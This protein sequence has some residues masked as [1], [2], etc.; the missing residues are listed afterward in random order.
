MGRFFSQAQLLTVAAAAAGVAARGGQGNGHSSG[1]GAHGSADYVIV[2]AGPAGVVLAEQLSRDGTKSVVLIEAGPD[3][4]NNA[5]IDTP[6]MYPFITEQYWNYT[7]QPDDNLGGVAHALQQ[8]RTIGGGSGVNGMAYCRGSASVFDDWATLSGN[9]G[10]AWESIFQDFLEVSHYTENPN[11]DYD[12]VVN[13]SA[14]G[15]G[16]LEVSRVGTLTGFE[17]PFFNALQAELGLDEVD[18]TDGSGIGLDRGLSSITAVNRTRSYARSAFGPLI[19][20]RSNV[21]IL[22]NA[23]VSKINFEGT[24]AVSVTYNVGGVATTVKGKEIIVSGGAINTPKLLML[25]GVGPKETLEPLGIEVVADIPDVGA[26]L[27]DHA[28]AIIELDV[29][30]DILTLYQWFENA[31]VNAE[32]KADYATNRTGI[33]SSNNG[34]TYGTYRLP[35]S[36]WDGIDGTHYT[37]LPEDR[38]HILFEF[39]SLPFLPT[40]GSALTTWASLVQP[41][42]SGSV[43]INTTDYT[44]DPL[45]YTNYYSTEADKAAIIAGYKL[46]MNITQHEEIKAVTVSQVFPTTELTTDDEIWAAIQSQSYSFHHPMG[47]VAIGKALD[48]NWRLNG[49]SGIRVVD[50]STFPLPVT[51]HPQATVYALANRAAKDV[52]AADAEACESD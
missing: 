33:L 3:S 51:C 25:S 7:A 49:L 13:I 11:A 44:V 32:A 29:D 19:E 22:T 2:G 20:N 43:S 40:D 17:D 16:P 12:Q 48:S 15:D 46:L 41:E 50:S 52:M 47:T 21:Q 36:T 23:W 27:R 30:P 8:G 39:S 34:F 5:T 35:D 24:T 14:Y 4:I 37:S 1:H 31:T 42:G 26:N 45:I 38:P 18:L 10:L 28:F 6:A 9:D